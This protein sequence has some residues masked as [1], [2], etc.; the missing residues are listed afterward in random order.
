M[1]ALSTL[2]TRLSEVLQTSETVNFTNTKRE[3]ALND[4]LIFD[5][6]NYRQ[7]P[8][9]VENAFNQAVDGVMTMPADFRKATDLHY[10]ASASSSSW[11]HY[12][13]VDQ[14]D[15][16]EQ[17]TNTYTVT[18]D[19][20]VQVM[21]LYPTDDQG[22]DQENETSD[23]DQG[24]FA[25]SADE[26]LFQTFTTETTDFKG[27]I[28]K[29]KKVASPTETATLTLGL[30]ATAS[31][32]PTGSAL[33]TDTILVSNLTTT[34]AFYYFHLPY[35]TTD[36]T[37]YALVLSTDES[38]ADATN[39]VAWEYSATSQTDDSRGKYNGTVY[40]TATGD[41][42][43]HTYNEV[44]S[45]QYLKTLTSMSSVSDTTGLDNSFDEPIVMLAAARLYERLG[46]VG[47]SDMDYTAAAHILRYGSGGS[48][49]NPTPDSAYGKLNILW[50][51]ERTRT[52]RPR[53][54]FENIYEQRRTRNRSN[55]SYL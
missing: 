15:F 12:Q 36:D 34:Y 13:S 19:S 26:Q 21:K 40:A 8:D 39:Y 27:A 4:A 52:R 50:D 17:R 22:V 43:F 44:F 33:A 1:S 7:W 10:G 24:L 25:T 31:N 23:T 20:D 48:P 37:E 2:K 47:S 16:L 11:N 45:Q 30:Y 6:Q 41:M 9:L 55:L 29:L 53:Q 35:D 42:Y 38:S 49:S 18:E 5:T 54:R 3:R 51:E 32:I 28:I 46:G 14:T